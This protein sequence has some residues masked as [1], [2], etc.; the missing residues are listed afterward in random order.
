MSQSR[1]VCTCPRQPSDSVLL[2]VMEGKRKE[3]K[4]LLR[5]TEQNLRF[6]ENFRFLKGPIG[7]RLHI[8]ALTHT[9]CM[10]PGYNPTIRRTTSISHHVAIRP[11]Y[12]CEEMCSLSQCPR[13][14]LRF[15]KGCKMP[16][17]SSMRGCLVP[18]FR[19]SKLSNLSCRPF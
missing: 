10:I 18:S 4:F 9:A 12:I 8:S 14:P 15:D 1:A 7:F 13:F 11:S 3:K 19:N 17:S 2:C 16:T 6:L 5:P